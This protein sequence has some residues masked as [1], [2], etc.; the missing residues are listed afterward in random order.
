MTQIVTLGPYRWANAVTGMLP[1]RQHTWALAILS[2]LPGFGQQELQSLTV[3]ATPGRD[4]SVQALG[5]SGVNVVSEPSGQIT[6]NFTVT[7]NHPTSACGG[8]KVWFSMVV[9]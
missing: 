8:Y 9:P 4:A 1:G 5:V 6:V 7:N 3:T 2:A